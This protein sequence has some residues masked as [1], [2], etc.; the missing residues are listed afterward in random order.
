MVRT[1][2]CQDTS[3]VCPQDL[4]NVGDSDQASVLPG[5]LSVGSKCAKRFTRM[6]TQL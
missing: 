3:E 6:V 4:K 2:I 5:D 1:S